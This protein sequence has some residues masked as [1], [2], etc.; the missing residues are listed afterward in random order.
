M[1]TLTGRTT[2]E[3]TVDPPPFPVV[4][5]CSA[6]GVGSLY[7]VW[8]VVWH[9]QVWLAAASAVVTWVLSLRVR[10]CDPS[11]VDKLWS[12]EPGIYAWYLYALDPSERRLLMAIL[13]TLWGARLTWN[14][15]IKGGYS[16]GEDYRWAEIRIWYPGWRFE[17]FNFVFICFFQ[18]TV[19]M[20]LAAPVAVADSMLATPDAG[21]VLLFLA[22]LLGETVAD[23]EM[24]RFQTDKYERLARGL[25]VPRGFID[26][27]LWSLSRHPNYFCEVSLWWVFHALSGRPGDWTVL[28]PLYLTGLFVFPRASI[29]VVEAL[30]SRKYPDYADYQRRVP[31]FIPYR[32]M[33]SFRQRRR[34]PHY[35]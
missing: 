26:T 23:I 22:L 20:A 14:F 10:G 30:A 13:A 7:A 6:A 33:S 24:F 16:G 3:G 2:F 19:L 8:S 27:G 35:D 32:V 11:I 15:Y 12:I 17:V 25:A 1:T 29:D 18:Q 5:V 34:Q 28:G 31:R 9:Q 21:L 4:V